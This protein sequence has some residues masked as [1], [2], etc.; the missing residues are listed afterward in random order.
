MTKDINN[1]QKKYQEEILPLLKKEWGLT[2]DWA[3]PRLKTIVINSGISQEHGQQEA[4]NNM[5]DQLAAI[6]GQ[7][8]VI[9]R[10]KKSIAG[11]KLRAGDPIGLKSTLRGRKMYDFFEKLVTIALPRVKDF[12]GTK[13]KAFDGK[14]NYSIGLTEQLI[15][16]E[17]NYDKI[18]K[19]RGLQITIITTAEDDKKAQRLLKLLGVPFEKKKI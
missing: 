17:V 14:G 15:F 8:P 1:L 4:L 16:P 7:R 9:T 19:V 12:Q 2:N 10:A 3:V 13:L 11:F 5:A 18:D 6:T